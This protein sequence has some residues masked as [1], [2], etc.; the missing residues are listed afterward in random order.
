MVFPKS[1]G[2]S[3]L[4]AALFLFVPAFAAE[5]QSQD[6]AAQS[7]HGKELMEQGRFEEAIPVYQSMVKALPGN[8]GLTLNLALAEQMA[9]HAAA[10]IPHFQTVLKS[11]PDNVP[12]LTSL[13]MA[14]LQLNQ[15]E[16]AMVPLKRLV[17]AQPNN[18]DARGM[19][20]G[21][22]MS[23]NQFEPAADNYRRLTKLQPNDPKAWYGMGKAYEALATN[24]FD[25]LTKLSPQSPYVA[26]LVGDARLAR[27]QFR[28]AFFFYTQAQKSAPDVP[29]LH[30]GI[31]HVY[32]ETG[33]ADWAEAE[34]KRESAITNAPCAPATQACQFVHGNLLQASHLNANDAP[35][36]FWSARAFNQLAA[37]AFRQLETLPESIEL[38]A[39]KAQ[40]LHDHGQDLEASKEWRAASALAP[41]DPRLQNELATSLFL[42]RDYTNAMPMIE[43]E[44]AAN[45]RS[46][47]LN[48]ML[49]ESLW[50]TEQA[51]KAVPYLEAALRA[52]PEMLPAHAALGLA[53]VSL[54]RN[55]EAVPHLQKALNLDDDGSLH[56]SLARALQASGHR[57]EA[58]KAMAEYTAIQGRNSEI[59][60]DV[61]KDA[62]ITAP[63]AH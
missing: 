41:E 48:F 4:R 1:K 47:D 3:V 17:T 62:E 13:A 50:R 55:A 20:A 26:L 28:S 38:H 36:L 32:R 7:A 14:H 27:R 24:R 30:A 37:Q 11:Q 23:L 21:A 43:K 57:D 40:N 9:G 52:E 60:A 2:L 18:V 15:P 56:Y 46:P 25:R 33:H 6:L 16:A 58:Q 42:G 45:P 54:S 31:A 35:A 53:L 39:I 63:A 49:G 34:E 51:E 5:A 22:Q 29:G 59:N 8:V 10:A 61:A 44:L 12:A 19:L